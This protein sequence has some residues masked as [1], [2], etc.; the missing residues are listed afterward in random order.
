MV[1]GA[2]TDPVMRGR[3][4]GWPRPRCEDGSVTDVEDVLRHWSVTP[5]QVTRPELGTMNEVFVV[6]TDRG[7]LVLRG[8][9]QPDREAVEWEHAAMA[10]ARASAV[11]APRPLTTADGDVVVERGGRWW[12]L[13]IWIHGDQ[14]ERGSHTPEQGAGMGEMLARVHAVL[15]PL[16][17]RSGPRG[18]SGPTIETIRRAEELLSHIEGLPAPGADEAAAH[19]WL[20][21]QREWL[22]LHV[23]DPRPEPPDHQTIHGDYHDANIVFQGDAVAGVLDWDKVQN[24]SPLEELIRAMHLSFS[25]DPDVCR[26]FV[27]GYRMQRAV[28]SADLDRAA[29]RYGFSRDRSIWL[30]DE[31]FRGGNERLRP[32]LNHGPFLPFEASWAALRQHL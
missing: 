3:S 19:R 5:Q 9:R 29:Q 31:L 22:R 12:S 7:R 4:D 6:D 15:K 13:L 14:P 21:G 32:L 17:S 25:L 1:T 28:D 16:Q 27:A 2:H 11:P 26:S 30:F 20:S 8:H 23:D 24:G 10:A 18:P